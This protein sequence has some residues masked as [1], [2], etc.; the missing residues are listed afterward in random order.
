MTRAA[1]PRG[2][3]SHSRNL[4]FSRIPCRDTV[5]P[6]LSTSNFSGSTQS[7]SIHLYRHLVAIVFIGPLTV[8]SAI[9]F[10]ASDSF[11]PEIL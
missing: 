4:G 2:R 5:N 7:A 10:A 3:R 6:H 1:M 11:R 9:L 8:S